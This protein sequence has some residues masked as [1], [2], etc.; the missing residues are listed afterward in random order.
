[1]NRTT[2]TIRDLAFCGLFA[3][4]IAV[5]AFIKITIP[6]QPVPMHFTLQFFFFVF[7][8]I[9]LPK[10]LPMAMDIPSFD[11]SSWL[12]FG[13]STTYTTAGNL[14]VYAQWRTATANEQKIY[15]YNNGYCEALGFAKTSDWYGFKKGVV[16][17]IDFTIGTPSTSP[18]H[19][20]QFKGMTVKNLT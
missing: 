2:W 12:P 8:G 4:L 5:G 13:A 9:I 1:M 6:V 10:I 20:M 3:A 16:G 18:S 17:A 19:T 14:T 11:I 7:S 15:L